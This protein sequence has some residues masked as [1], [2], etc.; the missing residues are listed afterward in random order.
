MRDQVVASCPDHLAG[1]VAPLVAELPQRVGRLVGSG[2]QGGL[3]PQPLQL[4][5][6]GV[7][8]VAG[9]VAGDQL[10][11]G[12][13][14]LRGALR[15]VLHQLGRDA[16]DVPARDGGVPPR[17]SGPAVPE[18]LSEQ[19]LQHAFVQLGQ[20]DGVAVQGAGVEGAPPAVQGL[21]AVGEHDVGVQV[22]VT[23]A[24]IPVIERRRHHPADRFLEGAVVAG[25]GEHDLLLRPPQGD[26][27]GV[28]V[29][30]VDRLL[31]RGVGDRPHRRHRLRHRERQVERR[32]RPR[33]PRLAALLLRLDHRHR[34]RPVSDAQPGR[35]RLD[36]GR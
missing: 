27:D 26:G 2:G 17:M 34:S 6:G 1:A 3:L 10:I 33:H 22:R 8:A 13:G 32:D 36:A 24:G 29:R 18:S 11:G 4:D 35:K 23:G 21:D 16:G 28:A 5:G 14:D 31:R 25:A 9:G 19:V 7:A 15:E 30:G 20:R 12:A